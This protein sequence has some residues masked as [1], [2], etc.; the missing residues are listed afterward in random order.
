MVATS[1]GAVNAAS[2]VKLRQAFNDT[3]GPV[4]TNVNYCIDL[5]VILGQCTAFH[6]IDL[7]WSVIIFLP[8]L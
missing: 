7:Y 8:R 3:F 5:K 2:C 6:R 1:T 4:E